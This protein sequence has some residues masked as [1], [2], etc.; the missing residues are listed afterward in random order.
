MPSVKKNFLYSSILTTAGYIFPM[1]TYPYVSRVLGVDNIGIYNFVDSIIS[2]FILVSMMGIT[3]TGIREITSVRN[4]RHRLSRVF[5]S[6]VVLNACATFISIALLIA[7]VIFVPRFRENSELFLIGISKILFNFLLIE[8]FYKGL[9]DFKFITMRTLLVRILFVLAIFIFVRSRNDLPLYYTAIC[10]SVVLNAIVNWVYSR[11]FVRFSLKEVSLRPYLKPF[12]VL[13]VNSFLVSMYTTFNTAY[14][15]FVASDAEVG[16]YGTAT[17]LYS[18]I[19]ALYTAFTGV[20]L[21]R[22]SSLV[23]QK[24]REEF[25]RLLDKSL[26][27][28]MACSIPAILFV[29]FFA[30]EIVGVLAG[31][32]YEGAILPMRIVMPLVFIIG[33]EQIIVLQA[34]MPLKK[35]STIFRNSII[36][37]VVGVGLNLILVPRLHAVGSS[38]VWV[39]SELVILVLSQFYI[40]KYIGLVFPASK[41]LRSVV[42]YIPVMLVYAAVVY[43]AHSLV[44]TLCSAVF[45]VIYFY[46]LHRFIFNDEIGK[47]FSS[48]RIS[49]KR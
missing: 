20:M 10:G 47:F 8:W 40:K 48:F 16:F 49:L 11:K 33:Y 24:N 17:K 3:V 2:Y 22:M 30:P 34:L 29:E 35:D 6:L 18:I 36:G 44:L 46:C 43:F 7:G 4:D 38:I 1:L 12:L 14:L 39:S 9:E 23:N 41:L 15:G 13:G 32:G 31:E 37:A 25:M 45:T 26:A 5:S 28:L 21:P 27:F 19:L 42:Y